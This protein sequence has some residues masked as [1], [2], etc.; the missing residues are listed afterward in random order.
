LDSWGCYQRGIASLN[1]LTKEGNLRA[2]ELFARTIE[3][4]PS[5]SRPHSGMAY[6][7]FR[8]SY[9]GFSDT[10][11]YASEK[12]IEYAKRALALDDGDAQAHETLAILLLHSDDPGGSLAAGRRAIEINPNFAHA[13]VPVG[14]LL[15]LTGEPTEGVKYLER[16]V[17]LNPDDICIHIYLALLADAHLNNRDY[18]QAAI[19]ARKSI[20]W[21]RDFPH[22]HMSLAS[23]LG[24]LGDIGP[25]KLELAECFRLSPNYLRIHP[26]LQFYRDPADREHYLDGLRKAGLP[27]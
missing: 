1:E 3:I 14:N 22:S 6:C 21:K 23:A 16:A 18:D 12:S 27:E 5:D 26:I 13:H 20:E 9:D 7:L 8:Y 4:D 19:C 24:H 11:V 2:Q 15:S 17:R 10:P 25:A